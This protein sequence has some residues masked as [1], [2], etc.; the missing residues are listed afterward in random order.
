VIE[1]RGG[2]ALPDFRELWRYRELLV[3]LTWRNVLVRY[4]QT[5]LGIAWAVVQPLA[6][7]LIF[8]VVFAHFGGLGTEGVPP[9]IYYFTALLPWTFFQTAVSQSSMSLVGNANVLRKVYFPRL[10]L[11]ISTVL[12]ALVDFALAALVLAGLAIWYGYY[13]GFPEV[14]ALVPLVALALV[15]ALAA[16]LWLSALNVRFRDVQYAVPFLAQMWSFASFVQVPPT[17]FPEPWRTLFGLNPMAGVVA[18]FRSV[19][20]GRPAPGAMIWLSVVVALVALVGGLVYFR[21]QERTFA[22]VV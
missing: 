6:L 16:G 13:P 14:L 11:P 3:A 4:K 15:T 7:M 18:G 12:T 22:D 19:L 21:R 9:P 5:A 8:T 10:L 2:I 17:K 20:L 1:P